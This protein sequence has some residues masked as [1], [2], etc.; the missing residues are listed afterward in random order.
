M[1]LG[2]IADLHNH[3]TASDGEYTPTELVNQAATF[4]VWATMLISVLGI[5]GAPLII[6]LI[7]DPASQTPS[8]RDATIWM[9]RFMF[10]YIVCMS[11]VAMAGGILNTWKQFKIPAFTPVLLNLSSIFGSLVLYKYTS[12]PIYGLAIAVMIGGVLQV[13]LQIPSLL[14][15]G[16]LP[17]LSMNPIR[18]VRGPGARAMRLGAVW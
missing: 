2:F 17:R 18:A 7:T 16:M 13:A 5:I 4:L 12:L 10:P 15:I 11:F 3:T 14:R 6:S 1:T 9:T 8:S